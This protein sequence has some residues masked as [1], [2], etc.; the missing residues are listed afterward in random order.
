MAKTTV[1]EF[2][3]DGNLVCETVKET[4]KKSR[5]RWFMLVL[6]PDNLVHRELLHFLS[7]SGEY[8]GFYIH[9]E[10]DVLD[11]EWATTKGESKPHW[12]V[13]LHFPNARTEKG[14]RESFGKCF[15]ATL[16]DGQKRACYDTTGY[17]PEQLSV[18]WVVGKSLCSSVSDVRSMS[19]YFLHANYESIKLGKRRYSMHDIIPFNGDYSVVDLA[20]EGEKDTCA[21]GEI[22]QIL[23]IVGTEDNVKSFSSLL[24]YLCSNRKTDLIR[25]VEKHS[26][27]VREL[28]R[29]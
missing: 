6:Y 20:F 18:D 1:K 15:V 28:L 14:V 7:E 13:M 25:Y 19:M 21:G 10:P 12:H 26:Y 4:E 17:E 2:D 11:V 16:P 5:T 8:Q 29:G 9:H 22:M 27:L 23:E 3:K 24:S